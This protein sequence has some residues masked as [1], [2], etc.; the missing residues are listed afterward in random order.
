MRSIIL[1]AFVLTCIF[2]TIGQKSIPIKG[3]EL[4]GALR[5][6]Q[7]G[8]AVMSGRVVDL[9]AH[10]K[11]SK[12]YYVAAAG[13]GVWK[14][15]NAGVTFNP[16]F[17][18]HTQCIGA[19]AVD[20][21][22]P[23]KT[24][25]VGTGETWTRNSVS[26]GDGIYKSDDGGQNWKKMGL[27]KSERISNIIVHPKNPKTIF[28]GVLGALWGDSQ[29]RGVY[30]SDDGG[31]T[32]NKVLFIN[33][34]TGCADLLMDPTNADIM[35][36]SF[37]EFRRTGYSFNSGG[38][39][40]ALYKSTDGGKNWNKIHNGFPTGKL[41]RIG[42]A[43]APSKPTTI[44]AVLETEKDT[45]KGL[46]RSEDSGASWTKLNGDFELVIRPFYFSRIVVDPKNPDI[47]LKAGLQGYISKDGGK[48]FRSIGGGIHSDFHDYIFDPNDS[49]HIV[50]GTDGGVYR[51]RDGGVVWE[52]VKGLPLSQFYHVSVDNQKPYKVY[53]GLQD[54][55]SWVGPSNKV[56]GIRNS[57]WTS[58][59]YGDGFRVY[60]HPSDPNT[61]YSEMQGAENIW[62]VNVA[63]SQAKTIKPYADEGDPKLRFN[64]NAPLST[65]LHYPDRVYVGSQY[66]HVSDDK[67]ETWNKMSPDLTTNDPKKQLQEASGGLS[68]DNSGAE[69]HC[70]VFTIN[71]SP[72][73]KNIIWV[74]TD[75]GNVQVTKDAG[76]TWTNVTSKITG[77]PKNT[78]VYYIE[79]SNFDANTAYVV[80]DGHTMSDFKPYVMKTTDGGNTWKSVINEQVP[81]FARCIKEDHINKDILY[82]GTEMGLYI[83][84]DGGNNWARFDNNMPQVAVHYLAIQKE[85]DA[86]VMATHGRG[87]I[88]IDDLKPL[89]AINETLLSKELAFVTLDPSV[90]NE[91]VTFQEFPA[92]GEYLGDTPTT[93]ARIVYYMNKRHTFGKMTMEIFDENGL[94]VADLAP[95]KSKGIN[96]VLWNYTLPLPKTAKGKTFTFGGFAAPKV[97]AGKYT[98]K[99]TKGK[100]EYTQDLV[101]K[102]DPNSIHSEEDRKIKDAKAMELYKMMESLADE[103]E[104]IDQLQK[105]SETISGSVK[106][107]KMLKKL[108]LNEYVKEIEDLRKILV[109]TTGDNY[110]GAAEPQLREKIANLYG[111]VLGYA[112]KPTNAQLKN[113]DMLQGKLKEATSKIK[114]LETK[115]ESINLLLEK[116]KITGKI[117]NGKV[118][119]A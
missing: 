37:W 3:D 34:T 77:V 70:T 89:R 52:M 118:V 87:V 8:P 86:L 41:G 103:V 68:A 113:L 48:T 63:K 69:N 94:K 61:V 19:V 114:N 15:V 56:G 30:R 96:E 29:E 53:G 81:V 45:D 21:S 111:E 9:E 54:N 51:S 27:E 82:L 10:P 16:I 101:L 1:I 47:I 72:V 105:S 46:Y 12:V 83:S 95:G 23:D 17:D 117:S 40:S 60:P 26:I 43:I 7:I 38:V 100:E 84:L 5:A 64:W 28:V 42:I 39:N 73:D 108:Q 80:F 62:R 115:A 98:V 49:N 112:G 85:A 58:V 90:I 106:D 93:S 79:P 31:N 24:I 50:V 55:G 4:F 92:V 67:G 109:V 11:D 76:K 13:G 78:W 97:P 59:G 102:Y 18:K 71:E 99:I 35:Y 110:V 65:S 88:I 14:T 20:P 74:G 66:V 33:E 22:D 116:N 2:Q 104:K 32:W 91:S 75:D 119:G 6:R 57:D 36:A 107:K 44:Y 25:W